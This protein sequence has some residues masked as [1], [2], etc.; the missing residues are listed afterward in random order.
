MDTS[1]SNTLLLAEAD[2]DDEDDEEDVEPVRGDPPLLLPLL[3]LLLLLPPPPPP[4]A[5]VF[6]MMVGIMMLLWFKPC[7][8]APPVTALILALRHVDGRGNGISLSSQE[9]GLRCGSMPSAA[10][11]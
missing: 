3:L 9:S 10:A 1:R 2:N 4:F 11:W 7:S 6:G 5:Q 8:H